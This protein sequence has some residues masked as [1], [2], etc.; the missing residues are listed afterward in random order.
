MSRNTIDF[1]SLYPNP[2]NNPARGPVGPTSPFTPTGPRPFFGSNGVTGPTGTPSY[3]GTCP[4][5]TTGM[6]GP[7]FFGANFRNGTNNGTF[8]PT[9]AALRTNAFLNVNNVPKK[10]IWTEPW[11][12]ALIAILFLILLGLLLFAL[13]HSRST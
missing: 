12:L 11:F 10:S 7:S 9:N 5:G 8:L 2:F 4:A 13:Y 3:Q 6:T 1:S